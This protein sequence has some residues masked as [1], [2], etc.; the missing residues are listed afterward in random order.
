MHHQR[1][2]VTGLCAQERNRTHCWACWL[3]AFQWFNCATITNP[4]TAI[5]LSLSFTES[6]D[7][8]IFMQK[9][10]TFLDAWTDRGERA[11]MTH[12]ILKLL[13]K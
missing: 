12:A 6:G 4:E 9:L 2:S 13:N 8:E 1:V 10:G 7:T 5:F 3:S 11:K